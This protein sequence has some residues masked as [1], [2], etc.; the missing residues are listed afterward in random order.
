MAP[1][2]VRVGARPLQHGDPLTVPHEGAAEP[3]DEGEL[4]TPLGDDAG[5][6]AGGDA[7]VAVTLA[8]AAGRVEGQQNKGGNAL[9]GLG[10]ILSCGGSRR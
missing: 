4:F 6:P 5:G 8:P 3:G 10:V 9:G 2:L 7:A 1:P